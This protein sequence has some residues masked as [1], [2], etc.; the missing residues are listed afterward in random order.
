MHKTSVKYTGFDGTEKTRDCYFHLSVADFLDL[1]F[2]EPGK[3]GVISQLEGLTESSDPGQAWIPMR[4]LIL[5]SYGEAD[6]ETDEWRKSEEISNKFVNTL[7]FHAL[8]ESLILDANYA[9]E[10]VNALVTPKIMQAAAEE[11]RKRN[12]E[13][14]LPSM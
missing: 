14:P 4:E 2:G 11:I 13:E 1:E 7:A 5:K 8:I 10:F 6:E 9:S 3:K 12:G